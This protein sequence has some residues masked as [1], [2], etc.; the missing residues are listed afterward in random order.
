M[1]RL[2]RNSWRQEMMVAI[3]EAAAPSAIM[4][5][6]SKTFGLRCIRTFE[7]VNSVPFDPFDRY[8]RSLVRGMGAF[9]ATFWRVNRLHNRTT[10]QE[11]Q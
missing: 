11:P 3:K 4:K 2:R 10:P 7:R 8:H 9:E 6:T 5:G 1:G